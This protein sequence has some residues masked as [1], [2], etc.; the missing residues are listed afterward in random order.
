MQRLDPRHVACE[1][2]GGWVSAGVVAL[3]GPLAIG[4][5]AWLGQPGPARLLALALG[6]G[7]LLVLLV[8]LN[9]FWPPL[10]FRHAAW[11]L[12]PR[13]LEIRRGVIV[14]HWIGVPRA[15]VQ[16]LDVTR[17]PIERRFGLATLVVHTAGTHEHQVPLEGLSHETALALRDEL[18][19]GPARAEGDGA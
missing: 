18:L 6:W 7:A 3:L 4:A 15:R 8:V 11:R 1:R 9:R 19:A 17:G 2:V 5:H 10:A 14:R 13:A 12:S 16:H